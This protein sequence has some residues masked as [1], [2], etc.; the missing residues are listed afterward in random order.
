MRNLEVLFVVVVSC[1]VAA[2]SAAAT[3]I[4]PPPNA[5]VPETVTF[6]RDVAPIL[7]EHCSSCHRPGDIAPM[8]L[9]SYD[10]ARPWAKSIQRA[11][12][13]GDMPPW[14]ASA[15]HGRFKNDRTL[16][17]H[18]IAVIDRWVTQGAKPG[19]PKDMP[20][21]PEFTKDWRLGEPDLIVRFDQVELSAGGPDV[22]RDLFRKA[23]LEEDRWL[24]AVEVRPGN[25]EV[26]HHVI[27]FAALGNGPPES[28]WLGAWA[29]GM[30]PMEFPPGT[31]KR[32]GK[33]SVLVA[34]MHYHPA[35]EPTTDQTEIGL[36]FYDEA[37]A[38][39]LQN[40]WIQNAAFKIP[41]GAANHEVRATYTFE[42]PGSIHGLLPHMHYR[43]KD[44]TYIAH[45][46][47]GT[48]ETLL[49]VN[50]Y[51][52]NWQ[53]LYELAEPVEIPAGTK[54]ECIAHY[55]N[56]TG[57]PANPDPT[58][59]VTFGDE[60]YDEMMIGFVDF[61]V[62]DG[63]VVLPMA[64]RLR[65][66]ATEAALASPDASFWVSIWE[67]DDPDERIPGLF[68]IPGDGGGTLKM[69]MNGQL[70]DATLEIVHD[71][72]LFAGT[73][74]IPFGEFPIS[75]TIANGALRGEIDLSAAG[76]ETVLFEGGL[77]RK[78]PIPGTPEAP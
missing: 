75:G 31:G 10:E 51:D 14:G 52:F 3:G 7:F 58:R 53:T 72:D 13:S 17:T 1:L 33:G 18:E 68:V 63:V 48:S 26:L 35:D 27:L 37:P 32:V 6:A 69:P 54:V 11:V 46:P 36:Y 76:E 24:R 42:N 5:E 38:A 73:L 30:A 8:A 9:L 20:A 23:D 15:A 16:S 29:A 55:D 62:A 21:P 34:D 78:A 2:G 4:A 65:Q 40:I 66:A 64:E 12:V 56:S 43:G 71:G 70:L 22:F 74:A 45:Y 60:S 57:N 77:A 49:E 19:D 39:E 44:F 50:D 41:A 61:T 25:R 59:D 28:G 47:D 67:S